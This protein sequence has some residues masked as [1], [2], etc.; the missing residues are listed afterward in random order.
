MAFHQLGNAISQ[1]HALIGILVGIEG[2]TKET[3][4]KNALVLQCWDDRLTADN[5]IIRVC[6]NMY[7]LQP[8][9]VAKALPSSIATWQPW[10]VNHALI[11]VCDDVSLV[12]LNIDENCKITDQLLSSLDLGMHHRHLLRLLG[13]DGALSTE[14][15]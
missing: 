5:A 6:D 14:L 3:F 7:V 2:V 13:D 15:R 12:P 4:Q 1:I 11:R 8:F 9:F 10:L